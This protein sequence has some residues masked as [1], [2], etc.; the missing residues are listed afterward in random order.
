[1]AFKTFAPGVL[2]SSDVNTFLMRQAV[3]VCTSTTRPG[4]PNEGMTIY[5]TD[6]KAYARYDGTNWVYQ[7]RWLAFTP[8]VTG[9]GTGWT[10]PTPT[11]GSTR[12][13]QVGNVVF[14]KVRITWPAGVVR[15]TANVEV[16]LPIAARNGSDA[17]ARPNVGGGFARD[18]STGVEYPI[19]LY[20]VNATSLQLKL[21]LEEGG[22][23][24]ITTV[25]YGTVGGFSNVMDTGDVAFGIITYE[26]A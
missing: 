16:S 1:M 5:E 3:I 12:Y 24:R 17:N 21:H 23:G 18:I 20:V 7:G 4:S 10:I 15:G 2:T 8:T 11:T 26:A 25:G 6:T 22:T 13:A 9:T 19:D 14:Y